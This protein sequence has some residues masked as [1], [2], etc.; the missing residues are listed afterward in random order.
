MVIDRN[1]ARCCVENKDYIAG[2]LEMNDTYRSGRGGNP[3]YT[4]DKHYSLY[5]DG[6]KKTS[7]I[8]GGAFWELI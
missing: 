1:A 5:V 2:S 3:S 6:D 7:K 8:K 4:L